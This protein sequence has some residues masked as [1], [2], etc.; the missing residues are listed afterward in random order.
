MG[1]KKVLMLGA[2][3]LQAPA[4][5]ELKKMNAYVV[6]LDQNPRAEGF[7]YA[8]EAKIISTLDVDAIC[9][10]FQKQHADVLM[11]CASDAPVRVISEVSERL[12]LPG[13]LS[14]E[15]ACAVTRKDKMRKRLKEKGVPVPEFFIVYK[16][17]DLCHAFYE[18]FRQ[19]C[20]IKP[21]DNAGS[22]GV[23]LLEGPYT[24]SDLQREYSLC[25]K[26]AR[27]G[28]LLA[29]EV[30]E[31]PEVS[32]EAL[33]VNGETAILAITDKIVCKRP[34]FVEIGHVEPSRLPQEVKEQI[35]KITKQ[36]IDAVHLQNGPSHTEIIVTEHGPRIVEIAARLG[37]DFITSALVPL[38]TGVSMVRESVRLS[39]GEHVS[40][41][42]K[43]DKGAA[44][45]FFTAGEDATFL[46]AEGMQEVQAAEGIIEAR[47]YI[48]PGEKVHALRS[49]SDRIGHIIACG[50]HAADAWNRIQDVWERVRLHYMD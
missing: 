34:W 14:Y 33:T 29:E 23:R 50:D 20:M 24:A 6:C 38:S 17:Q 7:R 19:K 22:R 46:R 35:I 2:G 21:S 47:L 40:V 9:L 45:R 41:K 4:I 18:I 28:I 26:Y 15:D 10:E 5:Q 39:M 48:Q 16:E 42:K 31:G 25:K 49:S 3:P 32:V 13:A 36:A 27:N 30:M 1:K 8:D 37:G 43:W 11:T 12:G 44:I